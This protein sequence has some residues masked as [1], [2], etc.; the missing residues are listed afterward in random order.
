LKKVRIIRTSSRDS[1]RPPSAYLGISGGMFH[2][3]ICHD[4]DMLHFIS[5]EIPE[6]VYTVAHVYDA[7]IGSMDDVDTIIST[8]HYPSGLLATTDATRVSEY[9]YDQRV[10]VF[11]EKG[12]IQVENEKTNTV[13]LATAEGYLSA[14]NH[15]SFP[16]RYEKTYRREM[17][18][19]VNM[20]INWA[21]ESE[22]DLRRH[23][24]LERVTTAAEWSHKQ[25]R[26]VRV[27]EVD[28]ER[29]KNAK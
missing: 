29:K 22:E 28:E 23:I 19:F 9:G 24:L 2:D 1:P 16:Q 10:E 17:E 14:V 21:P 4:I 27:S 25:K 7:E 5:G 8:F 18:H 3:M 11:G 26:V 13:H 12:M 6:S 20:V 15:F